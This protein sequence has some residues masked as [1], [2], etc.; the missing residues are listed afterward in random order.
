ME[1]NGTF[2]L[3]NQP[4]F[5]KIGGGGETDPK[6]AVNA[7]RQGETQGSIELA[8]METP[9]EGNGLVQR[10]ET[11]RPGHLRMVNGEKVESREWMAAGEGK[12]S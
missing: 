4:S 8:L 10:T 9:V 5:R 11:L 2:D 1:K 3:F 12:A 7:K 6:Q